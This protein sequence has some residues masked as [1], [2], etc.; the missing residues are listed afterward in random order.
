MSCKEKLEELETISNISY[1]YTI[2]EVANVIISN[3]P[4]PIYAIGK[5]AS[6]KE[7]KL[8][9]KIGGIISELMVEEGQYVKRGTLLATLRSTEIDAQVLK[10]EQA[11]QKAKRDLHRVQEMYNDGAA[12]LENL[13]DLNTLVKVSNA[14]V[15]VAMF[16]RQYSKI[17]SPVNGRILDKFAETEELVNAGQPVLIIASSQKPQLVKVFLSDR[18]IPKT[19]YGDKCQVFFDAYPSVTF[20]GSILRISESSDTRTGTFEVDIQINKKGKRLRNGY[21]ARVIILPKQLESYYKIPIDALV[22]GNEELLTLFV[23]LQGDTIAREI[24]VKP[25]FIEENY[26]T[27]ALSNDLYLSQ[28]ITS[29]APYLLDQGKILIK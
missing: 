18:D 29:G 7:V 22:E 1:D 23:P 14:D 10:A 16:N 24:K 13:Q 26:F 12:T 25:D 4:I 19:N 17:I 11:L 2:V 27:V 5:V 20:E 21:I 9:F 3:D 6:D 15:Q 28:V 8:S